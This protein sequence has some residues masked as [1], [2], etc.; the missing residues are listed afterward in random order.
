MELKQKQ[1]CIANVITYLESVNDYLEIIDINFPSEIDD[2][3]EKKKIISK[4]KSFRLKSIVL[5]NFYEQN[6][7]KQDIFA[8]YKFRS[9]F[10]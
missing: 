2:E 1:K 10:F 7:W 8:I 4:N 5:A 9:I 3:K 6:M